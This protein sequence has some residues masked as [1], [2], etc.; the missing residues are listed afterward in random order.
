MSNHD[1]YASRALGILRLLP[2]VLFCAS[3]RLVGYYNA[4]PKSFGVRDVAT[5]WNA[6]PYNTLILGFLMNDPDGSCQPSD[7]EH[8]LLSLGNLKDGTV[9]WGDCANSW[10]LQNAA[11]FAQQQR[12]RGVRLMLAIG[13]QQ[14]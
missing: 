6:Q 12:A 9:A 2:C 4:D 7:P 3:E 11:F 5:A 1:K 14:A 10:K 13:E 8:G